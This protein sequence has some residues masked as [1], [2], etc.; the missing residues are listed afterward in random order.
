MVM[1]DS[2]NPNTPHDDP[3]TDAFDDLEPAIDDVSS[4]PAA[5]DAPGGGGDDL[6]KQLDEMRDQMMRALADAENTRRRASKER[7]DAAKYAV[8]PFAR[9]LLEVAD[10]LR[11]ALESVPEELAADER[12][13]NFMAGVEATE[14]ALQKTFEQNK[15]QKLDPVGE[16][17]DPN[18]HEVMFETPDP[19]KPAG[20]VLQVLEVGYLLHDRLLR[21]ARV[22]VVKEGDG[23]EAAP[24]GGDS[25]LTLDEEV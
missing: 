1:T 24:G 2:N 21:P 22:G 12:A 6:Q 10:N 15:I 9:D 25:G 20:T 4:G 23:G 14:R 18:F 8:V 3:E 7:I 13:K 17:F 16:V 19:S 11:R 5:S